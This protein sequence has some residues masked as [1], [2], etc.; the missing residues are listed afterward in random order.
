MRWR[1]WDVRDEGVVWCVGV[2][3][4]VR[5][6]GGSEVGF[7]GGGGGWWRVRV[8]VVLWCGGRRVVWMV[9]VAVVGGVVGGVGRWRVVVEWRGAVRV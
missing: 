4:V 2:G 6:V 8:Q 5:G 7:D 3:K 9:M 1:I